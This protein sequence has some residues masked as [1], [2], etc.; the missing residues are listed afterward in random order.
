LPQTA[1][2]AV[3]AAFALSVCAPVTEE[4]VMRGL[5][6][7][8]VQ[9]WL[10]CKRAV[11]LVAALFAL[12]HGRFIGLP[13]LLLAGLLLTALAWQSGSIWPSIAAHA[14]YNGFALAYGMFAQSI[15]KGRAQ[16]SISQVPISQLTYTTV[17]LLLYALP[18]IAGLVAVLWAFRRFTPRADRPEKRPGRVPLSESWPWLICFALLLGYVAIDVLRIYG[19]IG[20]TY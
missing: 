4:S 6:L 12:M 14:A 5:V 17:M 7:G 10:G 15:A 18:F 11:L 20:K 19:I 16:I 9:H 2:P 13:S 1:L 8:D 3:V